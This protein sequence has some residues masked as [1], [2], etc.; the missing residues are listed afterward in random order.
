MAELEIE[1]IGRVSGILDDEDA[2][3]ARRLLHRLQ[4]LKGRVGPEQFIGEQAAPPEDPELSFSIGRL[5]D[6]VRRTFPDFEVEPGT[7][8][9]ALQGL[10]IGQPNRELIIEKGRVLSNIFGIPPEDMIFIEGNEDTQ[11]QDMIFIR[12]PKTGK[13][14]AFSQ[15][16]VVELA[17]VGEVLGNYV[18]NADMLSELGIELMASKGTGAFARVLR[19]I[20]AA[21]FGDQIDLAVGRAIGAEKTSFEEGLAPGRL[22]ITGGAGAAGVVAAEVPTN[23]L[24]RRLT[25]QT[26]RRGMQRLRELNIEGTEKFG[27]PPI[28]TFEATPFGRTMSRQSAAVTPSGR[29][30]QEDK[31][32]QVMQATQRAMG[33]TDPADMS[34]RSLRR[35]VEDRRKELKR[36]SRSNLDVDAQ[37]FSGGRMLL[38][39]D[40]AMNRALDEVEDRAFQRVSDAVVSNNLA[41]DI[42]AQRGRVLEL[43]EGLPLPTFDPAHPVMFADA[44]TGQLKL[45]MNR[46]A[47]LAND[48]PTLEYRATGEIVNPVDVLANMHRQVR[49]LLGVG[50]TRTNAAAEE[51]LD[52]L[53]DTIKNPVKPRDLPKSLKRKFAT[54]KET[55]RGAGGRFRKQELPEDYSEAVDNYFDT[56]ATNV[57]TRDEMFIR[58]ELHRALRRG[59]LH[60]FG[61]NVIDPRRP[62]RI[63]QVKQILEASGRGHEFKKF[64]DGYIRRLIYNPKRIDSQLALW[65]EIPEQG[66]RDLVMP[67]S[68]ERGLR[69]H[70]RTWRQFDNSPLVKAADDLD[71]LTTA[72][73]RSILQDNTDDLARA[74]ADNGGIDGPLAKALRFGIQLDI[75]QRAAVHT[76]QGAL[77]FD[78]KILGSA[79]KELTDA[80]NAE[81]LFR[82]QDLEFLKFMSRYLPALPGDAGFGE[83]LIGAQIAQEKGAILRG[84]VYQALK[85]NAKAVGLA[86]FSAL[87]RFG[88]KV[89]LKDSTK[90][91]SLIRAFGVGAAAQMREH[92]E[93]IQDLIDRGEIEEKEPSTFELRRGDDEVLR[94]EVPRSVRQFLPRGTARP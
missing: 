12:N 76:P 58:V 86:I 38:R 50:D 4:V 72:A 18:L 84:G 64:R 20:G 5:E 43:L 28:S 26:P 89:A 15:P 59:E 17:D 13:F 53:E 30:F 73:T 48:F 61:A 82:Q 25:M 42:G 6:R 11:G 81:V 22:A 47:V 9:T 55:P 37:T 92:E 24:L 77:V 40:R 36:A 54:V 69:E 35:F 79:I 29:T 65:E 57:A 45:L 51:F 66:V 93:S 34:T 63:T 23:I 44:P 68:V 41:F 91:Q 75:A 56:V 87:D 94:F 2:D 70:A 83:Q 32:I 46:F 80:P 49:S 78:P 7:A 74:L 88:S 31:M 19:G 52:I 85:G 71:N 14:K 60:K 67:P 16:D 10:A 21:I 90:L 62:E 39:A 33:D 27:L 1:G 8:G 3:K